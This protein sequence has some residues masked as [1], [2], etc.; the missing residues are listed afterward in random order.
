MGSLVIG[1]RRILATHGSRGRL[2]GHL[3]ELGLVP[4]DFAGQI[5]D[6][7]T[8]ALELLDDV[9]LELR[10]AALGRS[11]GGILGVV[12]DAWGVRTV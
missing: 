7:A 10:E 1:R 5:V 12:G 8:A 11:T 6:E 4:D 9:L 3:R 2:A